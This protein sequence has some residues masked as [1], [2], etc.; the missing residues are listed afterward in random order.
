M[1][2]KS[3]VAG[4]GITLS[5]LI[6]LGM[7]F[8]QPVTEKSW[9]DCRI[10]EDGGWT[11][12]F[13]ENKTEIIR[14]NDKWTDVA[15][16]YCD[17]KQEYQFC[18]KLSKTKK[19][20]YPLNVTVEHHPQAE[21]EKGLLKF[22][23]LQLGFAVDVAYKAVNGIEIVTK[24]FDGN[25]DWKW[26]QT[27]SFVQK[28]ECDTFFI[29][30]E[31][32]LGFY[33]RTCWNVTY[34]Q[35]TKTGRLET[36][37]FT[38]VQV[39]TE[40]PGGSKK[41]ETKIIN[42]WR[43]FDFFSFY[44]V[45]DNPKEIKW[46]RQTIERWSMIGERKLN[47]EY[48][49]MDI[50]SVMVG[51]MIFN[52]R[53]LKNDYKIFNAVM[54]DYFKRK[55]RGLG[56]GF[57]DK[58]GTSF[59]KGETKTYDPV[60]GSITY[61]ADIEP[62]TFKYYNSSSGTYTSRNLNGD[63]IFPD[64]FQIGDWIEIDMRHSLLGGPYGHQACG[65]DIRIN[66]SVPTS[67][68]ISSEYNVT[69]LSVAWNGTDG[70]K[71]PTAL[72]MQSE[73]SLGDLSLINASDDVWW[74]NTPASNDIYV[75]QRFK[76]A[77]NETKVY[78][79]NISWEGYTCDS[80]PGPGDCLFGG[81]S[82]L[83]IWNITLA[84]WQLIEYGT[85]AGGGG[86]ITLNHTFNFPSAIGFTD[87]VNDDGEVYFIV[88]QNTKTTAGY[89]S[90]RTDY[91]KIDVNGST[92]LGV[93]E[94]HSSIVTN[95]AT[96][97]KEITD[98]SDP[99][100][101][102]QNVGSHNVTFLITQDAFGV[103]WYRI[104]YRI[105]YVSGT[106]EG[107]NFSSLKIGDNTLKYN[108]PIDIEDMYD[109]DDF[110]NWSCWTKG[111]H[112]YQWDSN[113][114][115]E[116]CNIMSQA[117]GR[118]TAT[119]STFE[120]YNNCQANGNRV[121]NVNMAH[122]GVEFGKYD[123][124]TKTPYDGVNLIFNVGSY[125][126]QGVMAGSNDEWYDVRMYEKSRNQGVFGGTNAKMYGMKQEASYCGNPSKGGDFRDSQYNCQIAVTNLRHEPA[127]TRVDHYDLK[128]YGKQG[129]LYSLRNNEKTWYQ[130]GFTYGTGTTFYYKECSIV[131][132]NPDIEDGIDSLDSHDCHY[133]CQLWKYFNV[134]FIVK[135]IDGSPVFN[136]TINMT[137]NH[138]TN[139]IIYTD[140]NG[141]NESRILYSYHKLDYS[142]AVHHN[143]V[144]SPY[145]ITITHENFSTVS[146][147]NVDV[148]QDLTI[149]IT[150]VT[151][152]EWNYSQPLQWKIRNKS[153]VTNLKF[154]TTGNMAI[155]G[156]LYENTNSPPPEKTFIFYRNDSIWLTTEGDLYIKGELS[157]NVEME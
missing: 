18:Y 43:D 135:D 137:G 49:D 130:H 108:A 37:E 39:V 7:I 54:S 148:N 12:G 93:W 136:A 78:Q 53:D 91:I 90:V 84:G 57:V 40:R 52:F 5:V 115:L 25:E 48:Y 105:T 75:G 116:S 128:L 44:Y 99:S 45:I 119:D 150:L 80:G 34:E 124:A 131:M 156:K 31:N 51:N 47:E 41:I 100:I 126:Y 36:N 67:A 74:N 114:K 4:T 71:P 33:N 77:I 35:I 113:Y 88:M 102:M 97:W 149:P 1:S 152:I 17:V 60:V 21:T 86:D 157:E 61:N 2:K 140:A 46:G 82:T 95:G 146:Y 143:N 32:D 16:Y 6:A 76:F 104:R 121:R 56:I 55:N 62:W 11:Y 73:V 120:I 106:K 69:G 96:S 123:V 15:E 138:S 68:A 23:A 125:Y 10:Y 50:N 30:P 155:S 147:T 81:N 89:A 107:G 110:N 142:P 14:L 111:A 129:K 87:I 83:W 9:I 132:Y 112:D 145:N 24:N 154:S 13:W 29:E 28:E 109:T 92:I 59:R 66:I 133:E 70:N 103:A 79:L 19:R 3:L 20:C 72:A 22:G 26:S 27:K 38:V 101:G 118:F 65:K 58:S 127:G 141:E 134:T 8:F 85:V 153:L 144:S 151:E 42:N 63:M 139:Y 94:A 64:N 117:G 98:I 122:D